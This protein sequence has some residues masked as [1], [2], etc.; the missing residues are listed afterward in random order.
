MNCKL[1]IAFAIIEI[2]AQVV[3]AAKLQ[4]AAALEELRL[5]GIQVK[6]ACANNTRL[7]ASCVSLEQINSQTIQ[8]VKGLKA[9]SE[10][11]TVVVIGELIPEPEVKIFTESPITS[12]IFIK[13]FCRA[14][15]TCESG[16]WP[17]EETSE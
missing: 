6:T 10:C 8:G 7:N 5:A 4:H 15:I 3:I 13:F 16:C 2:I 9:S 17:E 12:V 1:L 14:D 11:D